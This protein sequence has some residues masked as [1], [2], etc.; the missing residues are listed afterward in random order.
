MMTPPA[1]R[2]ALRMVRAMMFPP[3]SG[4]RF[5]C[6]V[7]SLMPAPR[8]DAIYLHRTGKRVKKKTTHTPEIFETAFGR[9]AR[10]RL[11]GMTRT[12]L[13]TW[14]TPINAGFE[15]FVEMH[16]PRG[17]HDSGAIRSDGVNL[18]LSSPLGP[19]T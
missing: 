1:M 17:S 18:I 5:R 9:F 15:R 16:L 6:R 19:R 3:F 14:S 8:C 7:S 12:V 10:P 2:P 13:R 11:H 4:H